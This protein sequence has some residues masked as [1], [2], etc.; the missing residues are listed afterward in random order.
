MLVHND[1]IIS[2]DDI[3]RLAEYILWTPIR[4]LMDSTP[5]PEIGVL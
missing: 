2:L 1:I 5:L 4:E 3:F